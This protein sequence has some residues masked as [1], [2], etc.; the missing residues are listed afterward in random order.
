MLANAEPTELDSAATLEAL[1]AGGGAMEELPNPNERMLFRALFGKTAA[2][3]S[4]SAV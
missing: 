1:A 4:A 3:C 2:T